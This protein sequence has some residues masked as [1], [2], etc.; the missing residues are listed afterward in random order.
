MKTFLCWLL[1]KITPLAILGVFMLFYIINQI[2][3]Q[4]LTIEDVMTWAFIVVP[5]DIVLSVWATVFTYRNFD[6]VFSRSS[7]WRTSNV[8]KL[9]SRIWY[10]IGTFFKCLFAFPFMIMLTVGVLY[11]VNYLLYI[12]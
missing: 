7:R 1:T 10:T 11:V 5:I 3:E 6:E 2:S 4:K 12:S 8:E 9:D